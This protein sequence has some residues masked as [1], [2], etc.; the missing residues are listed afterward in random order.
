VKANEFKGL[1]MNSEVWVCQ[2]EKEKS[3][4][5]VLAEKGFDVWVSLYF[6]IPFPQKRTDRSL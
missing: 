6:I 4:P 3:L 1:L 5:F 2:L